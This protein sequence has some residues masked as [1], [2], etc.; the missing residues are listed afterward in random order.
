MNDFIDTVFK[1]AEL[2]L[3]AI[4]SVAGVVDPPLAKFAPIAD[5][6]LA[7]AEAIAAKKAAYSP[8]AWAAN[9]ADVNATSAAIDAAERGA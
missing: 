9:A 5:R 4:E 7:A 3:P 8:E 1:D 6:I 2:A